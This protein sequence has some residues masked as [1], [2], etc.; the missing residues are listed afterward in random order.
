MGVKNKEGLIKKRTLNIRLC[1][2]ALNLSFFW[3]NRWLIVKDTFVCYLDAKTGRIKSVLLVDHC[4]NVSSGEQTTGEKYGLYIENLSTNIFVK[5]YNEKRALEWR[6]S[7]M[8]MIQGTGSAFRYSQR[9]NAF[10]PIRKES[11]VKWFVDG[12]D[13]MESIANSIE[14][15][16]Q[17]IFITGFFLSPEIYLKRPIVH[18]DMWRLDKLLKR[19]AVSY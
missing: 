17:E 2:S 16:Q 7:I 4:F 5:C 18:G 14:T 15:A 8:K 1:S 6:M 13:Y 3:N 9:F 12:S 11:Q 10:A 19:K